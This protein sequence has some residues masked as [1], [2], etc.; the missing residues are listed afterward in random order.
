MSKS[1]LKSFHQLLKAVDFPDAN[2]LDERAVSRL[3]LNMD[4]KEKEALFKWI[5]IHFATSLE[6]YVT[7]DGKYCRA[8]LKKKKKLN[9]K[10]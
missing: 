8:E 2:T 10:I 7:S 6:S 1:D 9:I 3:F 4:D 5:V